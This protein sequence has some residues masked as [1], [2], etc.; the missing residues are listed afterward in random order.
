MSANLSIQTSSPEETQQVGRIIG[1][2]GQPGDIY[3]LT[4]PLGSGKTCLTQ[5]IGRGL[6]VAGHPRS[7]TFVL[8]TRYEGK[9]TLHHMDLYR[10]ND[11]LEAWDLGL[12]E[13]LSGDGVCVIEWADQ[14]EELFP[15]NALWINMDYD[16]L[17]HAQPDNHIKNCPN[18]RLSGIATKQGES[19]DPENTRVITFGWHSPRYDSLLVKLANVFPKVEVTG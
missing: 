13:Y 17:R 19:E 12:E 16:H 3:L 7:P 5:G 1:E 11:P 18:G 2:Q 9:L 15:E 8:M 4:G 6:G 10:I 14:A